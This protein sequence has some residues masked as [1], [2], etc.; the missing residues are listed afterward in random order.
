MPVTAA[1]DSSERENILQIHLQM[2]VSD[3]DN[4]PKQNDRK[5]VE[6]KMG[7]GRL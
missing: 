4:C 3:I 2:K 5:G 6:N 7:A 1:K